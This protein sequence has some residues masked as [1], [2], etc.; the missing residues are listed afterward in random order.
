M[1]S[2]APACLRWNLERAVTAFALVFG[3]LLTVAG[4]YCPSLSCFLWKMCFRN[5]LW[6][7]TLR[8]SGS[9]HLFYR[10]FVVVLLVGI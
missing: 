1:S 8:S 3:W 7:F 5:R 6:V 2:S 4:T 9:E 10:V